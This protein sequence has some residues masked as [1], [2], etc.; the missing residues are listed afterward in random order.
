MDYPALKV[1]EVLALWSGLSLLLGF[2]LAAALRHVKALGK[3]VARMEKRSARRYGL[4]LP[5]AIHDGGGNTFAWET[6]RTHDISARGVYFLTESDLH[7][8]HEV[9]LT[10]TIPAEITKAADVFLK[11]MG[12]VVRVKNSVE[13]DSRK[14]GVAV[15]IDRYE[16][17]PGRIAASPRNSEMPMASGGGRGR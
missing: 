17:I 1:V 16:L 6:G 10:I 7:A 5:V 9:S 15:T 2:G 8:G 3:H 11:I 12:K 13:Y 14:I 4:A